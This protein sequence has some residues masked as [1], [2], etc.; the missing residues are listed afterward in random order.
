MSCFPIIYSEYRGIK[1]LYIIHNVL[2]WPRDHKTFF[3]LNSDEQEIFSA[4]K[5]ENAKDSWH[6]HIYKQRN[7]HA[8]KEFAIVSNLR[9]LR[10]TCFMLC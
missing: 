9:F 1:D 3:M 6:F 5:Y 8:K 7:F 4:Y 2:I 10:R